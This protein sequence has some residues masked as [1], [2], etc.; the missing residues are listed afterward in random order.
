[1]AAIEINRVAC[2]FHPGHLFEF[3][4]AYAAKGQDFFEVLSSCTSQAIKWKGK[5]G[6]YGCVLRQG[7]FGD[8]SL[9]STVTSLLLNLWQ[10]GVPRERFLI[11]AAQQ[12]WH[13]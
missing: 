9:P 10:W 5:C 13:L 3:V 7:H 2:V 4:S 8:P 1:M 6:V 12:G 11:T